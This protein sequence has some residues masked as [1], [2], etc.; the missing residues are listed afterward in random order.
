MLTIVAAMEE[1]L[2]GVRRVLEPER[3]RDVD[4]HVI[5][6]GRDGVERGLRQV[7]PTIKQ[8]RAGAIPPDELLLLGFSGG[9]DPAL[10]AGDLAL[11]GRYCRLIPG[12]MVL[13]YDPDATGLDRS[14]TP[15][16]LLERLRTGFALGLVQPGYFSPSSVGWVEPVIPE[17]YEFKFLE[18][19]PAMRERARESLREAG[20]AAFETDS[21]T[22][23]R[24]VT[25][26]SEKRELYQQFGVGTVNMEDYWV[27]RLAQTARVPF[28]SVRA[29]LD[30]GDQRLPS[31]LARLSDKPGGVAAWKAA[32][33][34]WDAPTLVRLARQMRA[35][36]ESLARFAMAYLE[37]RSAELADGQVSA[38]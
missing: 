1:E 13:T 30:T 37:R 5:G 22:V 11:A 17:R 3:R 14:G 35:A 38:P 16:E 34:P 8:Q 25:R 31:Y 21:M 33:H 10:A 9:L 15:P 32:T 36:R 26:K 18:P 28:L 19:D 4:L 20:L 27:S 29:V 7:L 12:P 23:E 6:V 2:A 24:V